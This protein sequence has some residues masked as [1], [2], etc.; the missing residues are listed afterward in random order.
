M[1]I[2]LLLIIIFS[3]MT[4]EYHQYQM[5]F[6]YDKNCCELQYHMYAVYMRYQIYFV[7][8]VQTGENKCGACQAFHIFVMASTN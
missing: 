2:A 7:R 8:D 1:Y 6:V 5:L 4:A 3:C